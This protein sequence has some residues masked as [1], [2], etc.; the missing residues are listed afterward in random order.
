LNVTAVHDA[1]VTQR[2]GVMVIS[3]SSELLHA[4]D[5]IVSQFSERAPRDDYRDR[6]LRHPESEA[7]PPCTTPR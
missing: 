6:P 2:A 7:S 4:N 1:T 5:G 3:T